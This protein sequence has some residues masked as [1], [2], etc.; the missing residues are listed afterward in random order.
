MHELISSTHS[1][2]QR[3]AAGAVSSVLTHAELRKRER[4]DGINAFSRT[5]FKL[6]QQIYLNDIIKGILHPK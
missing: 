6:K 1:H 2:T 5:T 4:I 3:H